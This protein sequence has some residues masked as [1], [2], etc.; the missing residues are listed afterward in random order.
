MNR[1]IF[2]AGSTGYVGTSL[3]ASL[4]NR[5]HSVRALA[6]QGSE[7]KLPSRCTV[8]KGDP[9][10]PESFS[11]QI[12]PADTWVHLVGVPHPSPRKAELFKSIDFK[13]VEHAVPA[14]LS[15]GIAHFV[16]VS[17]AHPAP[18]MKEY[19]AVRKRCE[20]IIRTSGLNA[21][22]LLPWYVLGPGH[23]WPYLLKP[24]YA[25]CERI[26]FTSE[27]A[28]RLGLVTLPQMVT[29]IVQAIELPPTGIRT[30]EVPDIRKMRRDLNPQ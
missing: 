27:G 2:I 21:T 17:V 3:S 28:K 19:I 22:I 9:L 6:R 29:A 18:V 25:L 11:R 7:S 30:L 12:P 26:P 16:Y 15:A 20:Q 10:R 8:I 4:L 13:S 5:G 23:R 14:A 24:L 1:T